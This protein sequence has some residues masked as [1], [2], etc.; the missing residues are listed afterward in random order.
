MMVEII[1][2][3]FVMVEIISCHHKKSPRVTIK[4]FF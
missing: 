1:S 2:I 3:F 4:S